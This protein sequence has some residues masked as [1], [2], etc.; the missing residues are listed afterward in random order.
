MGDA[1]GTVIVRS[2]C[3][4]Y[5]QTRPPSSQFPVRLRVSDS[6][7]PATEGF[8]CLDVFPEGPQVAQE[9]VEKLQVG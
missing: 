7:G 3:V 2:E 5:L 9:V 6:Q 1:V 4:G 8:V